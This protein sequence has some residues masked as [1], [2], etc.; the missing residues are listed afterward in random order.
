MFDTPLLLFLLVLLWIA[1]MEFPKDP[2]TH[3][4]PA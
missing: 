4:E 1:S 2:P 3:P